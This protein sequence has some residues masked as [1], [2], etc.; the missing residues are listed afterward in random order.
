MA[1]KKFDMKADKKQDAKLMRG[2]SAKQKSAFKKADAK[3]D[4]KSLTKKQDMKLDRSLAKRVRK[5][6]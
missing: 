5:I 4:K 6:K 3:M 1:N 2:M